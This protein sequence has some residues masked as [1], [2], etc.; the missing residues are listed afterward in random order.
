MSCAQADLARQLAAAQRQLLAAEQ[1]LELSSEAG[2]QYLNEMAMLKQLFH[3]VADEDMRNSNSIGSGS[4]SGSESDHLRMA[5]NRRGSHRQ[6]LSSGNG[7]A[8]TISNGMHS[9]RPSRRVDVLA[10][11]REA[12]TRAEEQYG[13]MREEQARAENRLRGLLTEIDEIQSQGKEDLVW[14]QA[15]LDAVSQ[16]YT[17][18]L[19]P[20]DVITD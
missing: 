12:V 1:S 2:S 20:Q 10:Q 8:R 15:K 14:F 6:S 5:T 7:L 17:E 19:E 13:A 4:A 9:Q 16:S 18:L 3:D 11:A